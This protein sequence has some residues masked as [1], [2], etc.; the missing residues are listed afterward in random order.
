MQSPSTLPA[1]VA[2]ALDKGNLVEAIKLL[3]ASGMDPVAIKDGIATYMH[4]KGKP[5]QGSHAQSVT[6]SQPM[7]PRPSDD[8]LAYTSPA[9]GLS[10]GQ[11]PDS[12]PVWWWLVV[13]AIIALIGY[14]LG[15]CASYPA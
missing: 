14:L 4:N 12:N 11:V 6:Q 15:G 8:S 7:V 3:R 10:P 9:N 5:A 2:A 1:A 13:V